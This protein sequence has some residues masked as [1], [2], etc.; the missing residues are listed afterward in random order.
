M[1]C[2]HALDPHSAA[3]QPAA[4]AVLPSQ[5]YLLVSVCHAQVCLKEYFVR[6][7]RVYLIMELLMGGWRLGWGAACQRLLRVVHSAGSAEE[8]RLSTCGAAA[9]M[10]KRTSQL[11][12]GSQPSLP[13][14]RLLAGS[15]CGCNNTS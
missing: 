15:C 8:H 14:T 11:C 3:R 10:R 7:N 4:A 12:A 6:Q 1:S 5:P 9:V 13:A 2:G